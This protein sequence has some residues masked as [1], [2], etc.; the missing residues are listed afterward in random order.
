MLS[1]VIE[2]VLGVEISLSGG[3]RTR[4]SYSARVCLARQDLTIFD[5]FAF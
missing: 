3:A 5:S 1:I 4:N 2:I